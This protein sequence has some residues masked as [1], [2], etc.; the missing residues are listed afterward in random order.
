MRNIFIIQ[1]CRV[2][3]IFHKINSKRRYFRD[4]NATDSIRHANVGIAQNESNFMRCDG[5]N[6]DFGETLVRHC[7]VSVGVPVML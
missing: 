6:L 2:F 4:H 1:N 3:V 7:I 5:E